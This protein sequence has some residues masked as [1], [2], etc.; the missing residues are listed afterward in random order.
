VGGTFRGASDRLRE[1]HLKVLRYEK[2]TVSYL[3]MLTIVATILWL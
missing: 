2:R 1:E 3:E